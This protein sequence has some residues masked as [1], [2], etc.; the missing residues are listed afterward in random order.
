[1]II[2]FDDLVE[3]LSSHPD[4]QEVSPREALYLKFSTDPKTV[5]DSI[6]YKSTD[7]SNIVLDIDEQGKVTGIEIV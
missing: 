1:M 7:E 2:R 3:L 4:A 5:K 6:I